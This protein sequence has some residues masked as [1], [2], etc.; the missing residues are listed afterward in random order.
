M[1]ET[2]SKRI[3]EGTKKKVR[4]ANVDWTHFTDMQ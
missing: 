1:Y 2:G 3:A 4:N